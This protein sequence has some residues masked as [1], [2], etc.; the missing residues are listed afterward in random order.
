MAEEPARILLVAY[1][2]AATQGLYNAV[3][4]RAKQGPCTFTL[5]VPRPTD[6]PDDDEADVTLGLALPFLERAAR[7]HIEGVVGPPDPLQAARE[8]HADAAFDEVVVSALPVRFSRWLH[9]DLPRRIG[10]ELGLPVKVVTAPHHRHRDA[11][12]AREAV[13][14]HL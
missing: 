6:D 13:P 1:R 10:R 8:L 9:L 3:R 11:A 2:T 5:V 12:E 7:E 4:E 14:E